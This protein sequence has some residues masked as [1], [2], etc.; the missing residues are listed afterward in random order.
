METI[1]LTQILLQA[2]ISGLMAL[3]IIAYWYFDSKK[4]R[5]TLIIKDDDRKDD[6]DEV[7]RELNDK[8][9]VRLTKIETLYEEHCKVQSEALAC[10]HNGLNSNTN[11]IKDLAK[12]LSDNT[13]AIAVLTAI[14]N[15]RIPKKQ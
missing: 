15:E 9:E 13:T 11:A 4:K 5:E 14:I 2:G 6:T 8:Q 7:A 10:I 12:S 1:D 3:V